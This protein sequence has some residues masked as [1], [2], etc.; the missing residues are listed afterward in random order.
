M[1]AYE[2][3]SE[4][5]SNF[6][7]LTAGVFFKWKNADPDQITK[8]HYFLNFTPL[9]F[10]MRVKLKEKDIKIDL[11]GEISVILFYGG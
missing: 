9:H 4:S 6:V 11:W 2:I 3:W 10:E 1:P 8:P 7:L 5:D